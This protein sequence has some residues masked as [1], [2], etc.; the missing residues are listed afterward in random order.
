MENKKMDEQNQNK[1][2]YWASGIVIPG[3]KVPGTS[4]G[5][6]TAVRMRMLH[7]R[8]G[9]GVTDLPC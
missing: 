6:R 4:A 1:F 7:L 9:S 5:T 8:Q 2:N 3:D